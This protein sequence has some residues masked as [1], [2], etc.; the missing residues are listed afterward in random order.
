[1]KDSPYDENAGLLAPLFS[2][3]RHF[4]TLGTLG[5][6]LSGGFAIFLAAAGQFLPHD[7]QFLQMTA[8]ELCG[9]DAC[10]IVHFM[11]HDRVSFGGTLLALSVLYFW[12]I[13]FPLRARQ[14][15]AWW[16][17]LLSNIAGFASFLTY[18]RLGYLDT[19]HGLATLLL[20]PCFAIG[21]TMTYP[22]L[23]LPRAVSSMLRPAGRSASTPSAQFG[24]FLLLATSTVMIAAGT[25]IMLVGMT[26]VFVP[27]DLAYM[28]TTIPTLN[29]LNPRLIP[30]IA[31]DRA[32]FGS[33]VLNVGFLMLAC[34]WCG[35]PC[36]NLWQALVVAGAIGFGAAVGIHPIVG[37][38]NPVHL[39]PACLGA[40]AFFLGVILAAPSMLRSQLPEEPSTS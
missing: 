23:R 39:A 4:L 24:R 20:L 25:T 35:K 19:W 32:G 14:P 12:L 16:T 40:F 3:G 29:E 31:H 28:N 37:Y 15:W 17:L 8:R 1:M 27:Q 13:H 33:G 18:L 5:L 30:L 9:H 11:I 10:R 7:I 22:T 26:V 2:D 6:L 34:T 21:L 36:R 38:N